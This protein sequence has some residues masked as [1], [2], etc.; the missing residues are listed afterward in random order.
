MAESNINE[1]KDFT[2]EA[3]TDPS[4][5]QTKYEITEHIIELNTEKFTELFIYS[6]QNKICIYKHSSLSI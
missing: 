1:T 4:T 3:I 2:I 6:S 5:D